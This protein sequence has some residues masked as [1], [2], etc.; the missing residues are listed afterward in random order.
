MPPSKDYVSTIS[1][2]IHGTARDEREP[3]AI[4]KLV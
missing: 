4:Q 1:E 3:E 2:Y